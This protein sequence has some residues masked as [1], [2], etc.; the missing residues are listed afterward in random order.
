MT[1]ERIVKTSKDFKI[2]E[3]KCDEGDY[4]D[5]KGI[6]ELV[7]NRVDIDFHGMKY[8]IHP[9]IFFIY[10]GSWRIYR[11][12][13]YVD[14]GPDDHIVRCIWKYPMKYYAMEDDSIAYCLEAYNQKDFWDRMVKTYD[15]GDT[16]NIKENHKNQKVFVIDG[17]VKVNGKEFGPI[18]M[19][20]VSFPN[21]LTFEVLE[22]GRICHMRYRTHF[23]NVIDDFYENEYDDSLT[24]EEHD[25]REI[26]GKSQEFSLVNE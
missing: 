3:L 25:L 6:K 26:F 19:I 24:P 8:V 10:Q 16:F 7:D 22:G 14:F 11:K 18:S 17:K 23:Q 13:S 2:V 21:D 4:F 12:E 20:N 15:S 9:N 5:S 1:K